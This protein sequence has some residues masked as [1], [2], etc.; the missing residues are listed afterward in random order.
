MVVLKPDEMANTL[1]KGNFLRQ[2]KLVKRWIR[3]TEEEDEYVRLVAS[4]AGVSQ[5][6][7]IRALFLR[8]LA[9]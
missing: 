4:E 5:A 2:R 9:G 1:R 6:E 8:G 7:A 3:L